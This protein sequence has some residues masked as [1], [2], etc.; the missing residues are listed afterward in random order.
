MTASMMLGEL[1]L[2]R[3]REENEWYRKIKLPIDYTL[4]LCNGPEG[5]VCILR[6]PADF[7][8]PQANKRGLK[9]GNAKTIFDLA[10]DPIVIT[11]DARMRTLLRRRDEAVV[12]R[13]S[14]ID[15]TRSVFRHAAQLMA[16]AIIEH[17]GGPAHDS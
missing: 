5:G 9:V 16:A 10:L 1:L 13:R 11:L 4:G 15:A 7:Q 12:S 8:P 6:L 2:W 17:E 14:Q 3:P